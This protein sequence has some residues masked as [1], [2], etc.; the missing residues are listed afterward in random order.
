M[1][2]TFI[3]LL[4]EHL[5]EGYSSNLG[6]GI[7]FY[8]TPRARLNTDKFKV[9]YEVFKVDI[10]KYLATDGL[11]GLVGCNISNQ[12]YQNTVNLLNVYVNE[13]TKVC[14]EAKNVLNENIHVDKP[15]LK[16]NSPK[17]LVHQLYQL[18]QH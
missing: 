4:T 13:I 11:P 16:I 5:D 7:I 10:N 12:D 15:H 17:K 9:I 6:I 14:V 18:T 2:I 3:V 8:P 1:L